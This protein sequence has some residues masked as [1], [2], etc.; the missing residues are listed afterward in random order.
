[1]SRCLNPSRVGVVGCGGLVVELISVDHV[2]SG[3][4]RWT[5]GAPWGRLPSCLATRVAID[6][7]A[8][9][10]CLWEGVVCCSDDLSSS[11]SS[12]GGQWYSQTGLFFEPMRFDMLADV[13]RWQAGTFAILGALD[14]GMELNNGEAPH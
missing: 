14:T 10:C 3:A 2:V 4:G 5:R 12:F 7:D 9:R 1:M 6:P 13:S 8:K 11:S